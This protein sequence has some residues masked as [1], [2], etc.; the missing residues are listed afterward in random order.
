[1]KKQLPSLPGFQILTICLLTGVLLHCP[2]PASIAFGDEDAKPDGAK[3]QEPEDKQP[4]LNIKGRKGKKIAGDAENGKK[5]PARKKPAGKKEEEPQKDPG[6]PAKKPAGKKNDAKTA[7]VLKLLGDKEDGHFLLVLKKT[8]VHNLS[9]DTVLPANARRSGN[10]WSEIIY[11]VELVEGRQQAAELLLAFDTFTKKPSLGKTKYD[12][13]LV[14]HFD[15][16]A[17]ANEKLKEVKANANK[18]SVT[19]R[20]RTDVGMKFFYKDGAPKPF[21]GPK[22]KPVAR[23]R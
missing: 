14:S 18:Q 10:R 11:Q 16:L 3:Q 1:M 2:T 5:K 15:D 23:Q 19:N 8:A 7:R 13:K 20:P 12:W 9:R 17:S 21:Q 6:K 4:Q 22:K